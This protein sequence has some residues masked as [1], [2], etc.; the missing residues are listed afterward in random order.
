MRSN[1]RVF[2]NVFVVVAHDTFG[3]VVAMFQLLA[4]RHPQGNHRR[5]LLLGW[6]VCDISGCDAITIET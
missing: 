1:N 5:R 2:R 3:G 6:V 4:L